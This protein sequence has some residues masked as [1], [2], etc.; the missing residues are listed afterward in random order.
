MR[1]AIASFALMIAL[2]IVSPVA[3]HASDVVEDIIFNIAE[4]DIIQ[5][6]DFLLVAEISEGLLGQY[7]TFKMIIDGEEVSTKFLEEE[8][9]LTFLPGKDFDVGKH[10]I[11]VIGIKNKVEETL[12]EYGFGAVLKDLDKFLSGELDIEDAILA[13]GGEF[14][15]EADI[16]ELDGIGKDI[17]QRDPREALSQIATNFATDKWGIDIMM[18]LDSEQGK[19]TQFYDRFKVGFS[20]DDFDLLLGETFPKFTDYTLKGRRL[21]GLSWAD[22]FGDISFEGAWGQ[23]LRKIPVRYDQLGAIMDP[24]SPGLDL[25]AVRI[26]T[27]ADSAV[28]A[29]VTLLG[30]DETTHGPDYEFTGDRNRVISVDFG[31]DAG[32]DF[33]LTGEYAFAENKEDGAETSIQG[34]AKRVEL[35]WKTG[36]NTLKIA[37]KDIE[38]SFD[39][40]GLNSLRN[41]ISGIE[42]DDRF[43]FAGGLTGNFR[44]ERYH[45][46]LDNESPNSRWTD[47]TSGRVTYRPRDFDGGFDVTYR[48]FERSNSLQP[49]EPG[50]YGIFN[51]SLGFSGFFKG[52]LF[53]ANHQVRVS[54]SERSSDNSVILTSTSDSSDLSVYLNSRFDSGLSLNF[55]LGKQEREINGNSNRD[56]LRYDIQFSYPFD[57]GRLVL[58][59]GL[60][61]TTLDGDAVYGDSNRLNMRIRLRWRFTPF[62]SIEAYYQRL[63]FNDD[64]NPERS[65]EDDKFS[66]KL[67]RT[68]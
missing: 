68:F 52:E 26:G 19:Y 3:A 5:L 44:Y 2:A 47:S 12:T 30:G 33:T 22:A 66:F 25:Y 51:E 56:S 41:D 11:E 24:G 29:G 45:D 13:L 55:V 18:L 10:V 17:L 62:Y 37:Y 58:L 8:G 4:N 7:D 16:N 35:K 65:Y 63:D 9:I 49:G 50:A 43:S 60:G 57:D 1:I 39:S 61:Y 67:V 64:G 46:N 40:F 20:T 21:Q 59:G 27:D 31:Y 6:D 48:K 54:Y 42:I 34:E 28:T 15:I 32:S 38:P 23:A 36:D 53:G 14:I